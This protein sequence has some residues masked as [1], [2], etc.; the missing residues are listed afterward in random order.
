M[1][2]TNKITP[3]KWQRFVCVRVNWGTWITPLLYWKIICLKYIRQAQAAIIN[4]VNT[5]QILLIKVSLST[6]YSYYPP[7]VMHTLCSHQQS[8]AKLKI[9]HLIGLFHTLLLRNVI[10]LRLW[11]CWLGLITAGHCPIKLPVKLHWDKA[12]VVLRWSA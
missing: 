10:W 8:Q 7:A 11:A 1:L 4:K 3:E 6:N 12:A 5:E 9:P 2:R